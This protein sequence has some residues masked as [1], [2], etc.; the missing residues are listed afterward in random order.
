MV[1][2][3]N[4]SLLLG[5]RISKCHGKF[6]HIPNY[7]VNAVSIAVQHSKFQT[8][9]SFV[10]KNFSNPYH[11]TNLGLPRLPSPSNR[12]ICL[13][14]NRRPPHLRSRSSHKLHRYSL[15]SSLYPG[16]RI[17][18]QLNDIQ[19]FHLPSHDAK[20][21]SRDC[22]SRNGTSHFPSHHPPIIN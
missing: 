8:K 14:S 7:L 22:A 10:L 15:R 11:D 12:T 18:S 20:T 6:R 21:A 4:A 16:H 5:L 9:D 17:S 13:K 2:N 19:C 3:S 1:S